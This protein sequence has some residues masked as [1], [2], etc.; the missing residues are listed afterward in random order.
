MKMTTVTV[1]TVLHYD[2]RSAGP[3]G[4]HTHITRFRNR[5][6]AELFAAGRDVYGKPAT[7]EAECV[8]TE[9]AR[10]WGLG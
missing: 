6:D 9:T 5:K 8:R 1:Y 4:D 10:R 2:P 3:A 7:V